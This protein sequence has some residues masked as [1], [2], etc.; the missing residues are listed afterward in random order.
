MLVD[1]PLFAADTGELAAARVAGRYQIVRWLGA[2]GMAP[3]SASR[4]AATRSR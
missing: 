3:T 2:G 1:A 4:A